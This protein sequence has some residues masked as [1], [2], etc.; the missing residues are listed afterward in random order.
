MKTSS[1]RKVRRKPAPKTG[2]KSRP[3]VGFYSSLTL[4]STKL[5]RAVYQKLRKGYPLET[6]RLFYGISKGPMSRWQ[7][8]GEAYLE[9]SEVEEHASCAHFVKW[10][11][12]GLAEYEMARLD[13]L[14]D[15][16]NDQWRRDLQI[17]KLRDP[18]HY[19][20]DSGGFDVEA[21]D[22]DERYL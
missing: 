19:H 17:L 12:R 20:E 22:P 1:V 21:A 2:R 10:V 9:G 16:D 8:L 4:P 11:Q 3:K 5:T 14:H 18:A 15:E 13:R 7:K 6:I